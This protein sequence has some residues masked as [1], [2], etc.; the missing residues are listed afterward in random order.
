VPPE[1]RRT[2]ILDKPQ[3]A[4]AA[5]F[6][7][8]AIHVQH[9]ND[10]YSGRELILFVTPAD[11]RHRL[12]QIE[13]QFPWNGVPTELPRSLWGQGFTGLQHVYGEHSESELQFV[14]G[15]S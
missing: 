1:Q 3:Q 10:R 14:C 6:R 12:A 7:D 13:Y 11:T 15:V 5:R 9:F 8:L 2:F 4:N